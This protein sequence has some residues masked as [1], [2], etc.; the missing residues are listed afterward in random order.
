MTTSCKAITYRTHSL[1]LIHLE[2]PPALCPSLL[3]SPP[4]FIQVPRSYVSSRLSSALA[5]PIQQGRLAQKT[6]YSL[7][8]FAFPAYLVSCFSFLTPVCLTF[9]IR[10]PHILL[11][12]FCSRSVFT[13]HPLSP[14][15]ARCRKH[16]LWWS[17]EVCYIILQIFALVNIFSCDLPCSCT[18]AVMQGC[19]NNTMSIER[20][21]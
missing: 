6:L 5:G 11:F 16:G 14:P 19:G 4:H 3:I 13:Q 10:I 18:Q 8:S 20:V 12:A 15:R 17:L 2:L 21:Q 9:L 7:T 1:S